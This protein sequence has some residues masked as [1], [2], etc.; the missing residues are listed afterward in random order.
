MTRQTYAC[1]LKTSHISKACALGAAMGGMRPEIRGR[2]A[3][4][5]DNKQRYYNTVYK[6]RKR[7]V[8][9]DV[10]LLGKNPIYILVS[11]NDIYEKVE[12]SN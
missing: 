5:V 2:A 8:N 12:F 4:R 1:L 3:A 11:S 10:P 6:N 9:P 7:L